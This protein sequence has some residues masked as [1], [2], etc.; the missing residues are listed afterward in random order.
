MSHRQVLGYSFLRIEQERFLLE[1]EL[2]EMGRSALRRRATGLGIDEDKLEKADDAETKEAFIEL[3][4]QH[5]VAPC[6]HD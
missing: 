4:L 3:I 6:M 1:A 5:E 2:S